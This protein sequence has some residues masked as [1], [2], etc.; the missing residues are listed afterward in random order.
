M[1]KSLLIFVVSILLISCIGCCA[2]NRHIADKNASNY[3]VN[4][5]FQKTL[6]EM[7]NNLNTVCFNNSVKIDNIQIDDLKKYGC[8]NE[9]AI[10]R[11]KDNQINI[12]FSKKFITE[13]NDWPLIEAIMIHEMVHCYL[14]NSGYIS[15]N[16]HD[17]FFQEIMETATNNYCRYHKIKNINYEDVVAFNLKRMNTTMY[18]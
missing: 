10:A 5:S 14:Y 2:S 8:V 18:K 12:I 13:T 4:N 6:N 9:W 3:F 11:Y 15:E 7:F 1:R 17:K 16:P